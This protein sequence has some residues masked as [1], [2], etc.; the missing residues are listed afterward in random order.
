MSSLRSTMVLGLVGALSITSAG[1]AR[2]QT[3][4]EATT[5]G[6]SPRHFGGQRTFGF[7]PFLGL[8][9]LGA[10]AGALVAPVGFWVSGGYAPVW[11]FGNKHD[12]TRTLTFDGY[13]SA[14]L[15]LDVSVL[16]VLASSRID[17]GVIA[18]YRYNT[19]LSHGIGAGVALT[20]DFSRTVVGFAS[21]ELSFFPQ[22]QDQLTNA[23]YPTDRDASLPWLQGGVNVGLMFFP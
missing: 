8:S 7:G 11:V 21:Y 17:A 9:G 5:D 4:S 20:C 6:D 16:P 3:A 19:L 12:T 13:S 18:G 14:Q 22:A 1:A 2:A 10:A 23:G 15:N